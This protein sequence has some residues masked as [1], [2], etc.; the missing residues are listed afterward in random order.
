VQAL[1]AHG[2]S[3]AQQ[4]E[5]LQERKA[6][7]GNQIPKI[8]TQILF[9]SI[10][11]LSQLPGERAYHYQRERIAQEEYRIQQEIIRCNNDAVAL[12]SQIAVLD[13]ELSLL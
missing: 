10:T 2:V 4:W 6:T 12:Q 13:F 3:L 11:R 7:L 8:A 5:H 9:A 1:I